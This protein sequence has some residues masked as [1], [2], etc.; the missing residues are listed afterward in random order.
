MATLDELRARLS[1]DKTTRK[2]VDNT[3]LTL[4]EDKVELTELRR[5]VTIDESVIPQRINQINEY[6]AAGNLPGLKEE[7]MRVFLFLQKNPAIESLILDTD[8]QALTRA[9]KIFSKTAA[10][11]KGT[12]EKKGITGKNKGKFGAL[13][14]LKIP[15]FSG[16]VNL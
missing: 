4:V 5:E 13:A 3:K 9:S 11:L 14:N 15:D 6:I 10:T 2:T 8:V 12:K 7:L 1:Q 16:K